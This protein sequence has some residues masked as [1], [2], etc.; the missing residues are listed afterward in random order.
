MTGP[1]LLIRD[2]LLQI[3]AGRRAIVLCGRDDD[4]AAW[5]GLLGR[6]RPDRCMTVALDA[7]ARDRPGRQGHAGAGATGHLAWQHSVIAGLDG[8]GWLSQAADM[9]DPERKAVLILPDPLDPPAAGTRP[10]IGRRPAAWRLLED[11]TTV[12]TVWDMLGVQRTRSLVAD[13]ANFATDLRAAGALIDRGTGVVCSS[14]SADTPLAGADGVTWWRTGQPPRLTS[15]P[16]QGGVRVRLMPLLEGLPVRLHGL[17]TGTSVGCFP[18]LE[19]VALPRTEHGTFLCAGAVNTLAE[20]AALSRRTERIG[21]ALRTQFGY[22][23]AFSADGIL[24]ED[25]FMPTDLNPRLTSAM[26]GAPSDLRVLLQ[27][28]NLLA[29]EGTGPGPDVVHQ[30]S[31]M[32]FNRKTEY[33]LY[34]AAAMASVSAACSA[35]VRW[36]RDH[37]ITDHD[38]NA[39]GNL[40]LQPSPRGW[41]LT[42]RLVADR[43]PPERQLALLA[44]EVFQYCDRNW[45]TDFGTLEPPFGLRSIRT[46]QRPAQSSQRL[47]QLTEAG[48]ECRL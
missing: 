33:T 24:T 36:N 4:A 5:R 30:L 23:G 19:V 28:A 2:L 1:D 45:G 34:G 48:G 37:L 17:V 35:A 42:A 6:E 18:P 26:E 8:S 21:A 32:I 9:F 31:G 12:D 39:D 16:R 29:R 38:G 41:Q 43:L 11:K 20:K 10:R 27:A 46:S 47:D 44:V 25:G 3:L 40:T 14:Q 13:I 15:P 7:T 22:L